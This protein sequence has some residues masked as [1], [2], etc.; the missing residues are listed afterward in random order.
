MPKGLSSPVVVIVIVCLFFIGLSLLFAPINVVKVLMLWPLLLKKYLNLNFSSKGDE[1]MK[2]LDEN[3]KF[4]GMRYQR[5]LDFLRVA[6]GIAILIAFAALC[7]LLQR[8]R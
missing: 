4:Y 6:G 8:L 3:P 1:I 7:G 5:Q 2:L